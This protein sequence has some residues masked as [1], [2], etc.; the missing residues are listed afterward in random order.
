MQY[1][2]SFCFILGR[3]SKLM[4]NAIK[5]IDKDSP[6][7]GKVQPGDTLVAINSNKIL[8]VLDYKFFAY[9]TRLELRLRRPDG[10]EYSLHVT[11]NEPTDNY[12]EI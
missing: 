7:A 11:K 5:A 6:L 3:G 9:D 2:S 1:L 8:D 10:S 4:D 12:V